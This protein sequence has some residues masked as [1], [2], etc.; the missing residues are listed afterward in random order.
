MAMINI[1]ET[2]DTFERYKMPR[3]IAKIEGKGNGIKTVVVNMVEIA[4]ALKRPPIY[5]TKYFGC[6]LGAQIQVDIKNQRYIVN[7]SHTAER[8]QELLSGFIKKYVLCNACSNPETNLQV[9]KQNILAT[10]SACGHTGTIDAIGRFSS[11]LIKHPPDQSDSPAPQKRERRKKDKRGENGN[12]NGTTNGTQDSGEQND[13]DDD[14][15]DWFEETA[16]DRKNR[17]RELT[18]HVRNLIISDEMEKPEEERLTIFYNYCK[19]LLK[20]GSLT[21]QAKLVLERADA[22]NIKEKAPLLLMDL[23]VFLKT[24]Q[25]DLEDNTNLFK[26]FTSDNTRA[27]RNMLGGL[28]KLVSDLGEAEIKKLI[29]PLLQTLYFS[30]VVEEKGFFEWSKRCSSRY[31]GSEM[32]RII[33]GAAKPFMDWLKEAE[34]R[35][36]DEDDSPEPDEEVDS[37]LQV[38]FSNSARAGVVEVKEMEEKKENLED[39][40]IDNI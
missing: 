11:Y 3:L 17:E 39:L 18:A 40:D 32:S 25:K 2:S 26:L 35:D 16:E 24:F 1:R 33:H 36:S 9:K 22:L 28:E 8:L 23:V 27:Q 30:D 38:D 20:N 31:V 7:G 37:D 14:D 21:P 15:D 10:C 12:G 6:E 13:D 34:E 5:P 19:D 4:R 29:P